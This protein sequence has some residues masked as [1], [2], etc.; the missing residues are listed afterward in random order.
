LGLQQLIH[1]PFIAQPV[2]Q[3][4]TLFG[5]AA[6]NHPNA[7]APAGERGFHQERDFDSFR[8]AGQYLVP[9]QLVQLKIERPAEGGLGGQD[10]AQ[11][12][13]VI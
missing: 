12:H 1:G 2:Q 8:L 9:N 7:L 11:G 4:A 6:R 13:A 3:P 5:G 10:F